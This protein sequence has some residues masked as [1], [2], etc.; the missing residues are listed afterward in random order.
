M[1]GRTRAGKDGSVQTETAP[2]FTEPESPAV[3][4]EW[5]HASSGRRLRVALFGERDGARG[6]VVLSPGRTEP[7]EKY[8]EVVADLRARGFVVLA[9]D[10]AGQGLSTRFSEDRL[11]GDV[12]GGCGAFLSDYQDMM[13]AYGA[14]LPRPWVAMGHSMGGALTALVL[15]ENA[16]RFDAAALCAP[17]VE[18]SAGKVP[19][20]LARPVIGLA[21]ATGRGGELARR[22][23]DPAEAAFETNLLTHDRTRYERMIALYRAHPEL[24]LGEPT[25]RWLRFGLELRDRLLAPEFAP[26]I[27][28]P[29]LIVG[30]GADQIVHTSA[31]R[32][33]A[34]RIPGARY[35]ELPGAF[36]EI[37]METDAL[38]ARFFQCFDEQVE[39][40]Q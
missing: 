21:V 8:L 16:V 31:A 13:A 14:R 34:A 6:S 12:V 39:R 4:S 3:S 29:L 25:W 36:H 5:L 40:F 2:L 37:L 18:F 10:W 27:A 19:I 38:R 33:F 9:H 30:A 15:G 23:A 22:Q 35:E 20:W 1:D 17:M 24:R 28:C 11:A 32:T 26:R 7:I